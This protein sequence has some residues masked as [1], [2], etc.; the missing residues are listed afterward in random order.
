MSRSTALRH[1]QQLHHPAG[2]G[3]LD[4]GHDVLAIEGLHHAAVRGVHRVDQTA[5]HV[6][7]HRATVW[8]A[9]DEL[10]VHRAQRLGQEDRAVS[11]R[12]RFQ[13]RR[14]PRSSTGPGHELSVDAGLMKSLVTS[15]SRS[16]R[17]ESRG[18]E[19]VGGRVGWGTPR[20]RRWRSNSATRRGR[21][22]RDP[23]ASRG[24]PRRATAGSRRRCWSSE[25]GEEKLGF[26]PRRRR[27]RR[28]HSG[29]GERSATRRRPGCSCRRRGGSGAARCPRF[30]GAE[31]GPFAAP[32]RSSPSS[33]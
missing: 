1:R 33:R 17:P 6:G 16:K 12:E 4:V 32:C 19:T 31:A 18:V 30:R 21:P 26:R 22:R 29:R 2:D 5:E 13:K 10:H 3:D 15:R 7:G 20:S 25:P 28:C 24:S 23:S 27:R 11:R 14:A 8:I 9:G